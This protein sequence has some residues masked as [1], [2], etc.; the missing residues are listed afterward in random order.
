ME[1]RSFDKIK[2]DFIQEAVGALYQYYCTDND[3]MDR[4]KELHKNAMSYIEQ[5]LKSTAHETT[6]LWPLTSHLQ[7]HP[8]KMNKAC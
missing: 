5:I 6:A 7:N 4:E 3:K 2:W 8:N 1:V